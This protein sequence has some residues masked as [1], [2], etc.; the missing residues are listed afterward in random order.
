MSAAVALSWPGSR[1]LL[2]WWRELAER[3][4]RQLYVSRLLFHRLEALVRVTRTHR[5]DRW[6]QAFLRLASTRVPCGGEFVSSFADLQM[7]SQVLGQLVRELTDAGLLHRNGSGLWRMTPA[8]QQAL[9]TGSLPVPTEER[10]SFTF[11]DNSS[12]GRPPHFLS[13]ERPLASPATAFPA[14]VA[15]CS[16]EVTYL[17]ACV[18]Q[19]AEWKRRYHFPVEVE[20]LLPPHAEETPA[21]NSPRVILDSLESQVLVFVRTNRAPGSSALLGY[22][23]R[24]EGWTRESEPLVLLAEG[25]KEALPDLSEE[26][27]LPLW[28]Q[29]WRAW[30]HPRGLPP[31]EVEACR[32]ERVDHRLLIHAPPRLIERLRTARSDAV[33]HEA[34]LLAGEG[35][36]RTAAQIELHPL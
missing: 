19:T 15:N 3:Q 6:Q 28:Q 16:F 5:L 9:A 2:G 34:W 1:V 31:A 36:T 7:D 17:E 32:L 24:A 13:L 21:V 8:G 27:P 10:R 35:R 18:R 23:V 12:L 30:S 25:W 22:S 4:P 26:P 29:A 33:K 14:E 20:T 11:V